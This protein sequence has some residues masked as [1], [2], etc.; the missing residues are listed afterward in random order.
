MSLM[1]PS[2]FF[3]LSH[4]FIT[5][6]SI[7]DFT[8]RDS[9]RLKKV[10]IINPSVIVR[11][12]SKAIIFLDATSPHIGKSFAV[13]CDQIRSIGWFLILVFGLYVMGV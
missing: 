13:Y 9:A 8:T 4:L 7:E 2:L 6:I 1:R 5:G 11:G 12:F 10:T 3:M